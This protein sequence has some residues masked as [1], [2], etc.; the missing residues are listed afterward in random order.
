MRA[1]SK[2]VGNRGRASGVEVV[3]V[4]TPSSFCF[5]SMA[6]SLKPVWQNR[7][8]RFDPKLCLGALSP[9]RLPLAST[10]GSSGARPINQR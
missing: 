3:D 8:R 6:F 4:L 2:R 7:L 10:A 9:T 1:R 5:L